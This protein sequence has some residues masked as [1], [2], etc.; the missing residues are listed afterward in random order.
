MALPQP[1]L[2]SPCLNLPVAREFEDLEG[3][4]DLPAPAGVAAAA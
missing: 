2:H 1:K 3:E 4:G